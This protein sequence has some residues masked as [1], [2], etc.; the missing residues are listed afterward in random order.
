VTSGTT[1]G[2][3]ST[4]VTLN[5][6]T[7]GLTTGVY[8]ANVCVTSNDTDEASLRVPVVLTVQ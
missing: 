3:G 4:P 1:A 2:G 6:A 7:A 5:I 8:R